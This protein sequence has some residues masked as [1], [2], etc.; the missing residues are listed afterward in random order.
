MDNIDCN[1]EKFDTGYGDADRVIIL[2]L[3][4]GVSL[5]LYGKSFFKCDWR[6]Y[7]QNQHPSPVHNLTAHNV[8]HK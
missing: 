1:N 7:Q 2:R 8:V 5:P 6:M 4:S 3:S